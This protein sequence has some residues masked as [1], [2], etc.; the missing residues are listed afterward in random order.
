MTADDQGVLRFST[1]PF[2]NTR[3]FY[4]A[5]ESGVVSPDSV[6]VALEHN[7]S[8]VKDQKLICGALDATTMSMGKYVTS[9]LVSDTDVVPT[10]PL[11]VAAGLT[12]ER[13]NG[14]FVA[15]HSGIETP[16][17]LAGKRVG[18]HDTTLAMTY[19]KAILE[20][21]YG[22]GPDDVEWVVD[23]HHG[24]GEQMAAGDLDAVERIN[25]WYWELRDGDDHRLL[26]DMG[27]EWQTLQGYAPLVH[28]VAVDADRYESDPVEIEA[29]VTA[30]RASRE[31][32]NDHYEDVLDAFLAE[33]DGGEYDGALTRSA[34][35]Q[36]TDGVDCPF[37]LG[38]D[39]R[40]NVLD[41]MSYADRYGVFAS[42][43]I[44]ESRLFPRE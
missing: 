20:D 8:P 10:D 29:F 1:T 15:S 14:V 2:F 18:I 31:Y 39:Q 9:K 35:E 23:T 30:L 36:L 11:A 22:V 38:A 19:H 28:L 7:H 26:Y 21:G 27:E 12:Y 4:Y 25:D 34:L 44:P 32:R 24:L 6:D 42:P 43:P 17:D 33:D 16:E 37:V 3:Q 13:G 41:W 5:L 40:Q